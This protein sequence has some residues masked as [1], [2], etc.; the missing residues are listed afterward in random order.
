MLK[1][2]ALALL[3]AL[4]MLAPTVGLVGI[5]LFATPGTEAVGAGCLTVPGDQDTTGPL[6]DDAPVPR[7]AR[8]WIREAARTCPHLPEVWI[9]AVMYQES[10]FDPTVFADDVNGGTWGLFQI[11]RY[12]WSDVYGPW[13][14]DK[15]HNG[16][17]DIKEPLIHAKYGAKYFCDLLKL[18]RDTRKEHPGWA[19]TKDLT[20]LEALAVAHNGGPGRLETYPDIAPVTREY[21]K[22]VRRHMKQWADPNGGKTDTPDVS[23]TRV[24]M[25][26]PKG[27]YRRSS[28]YGPRDDPF[29]GGTA[30]HYGQ[31][32]AADDGTPI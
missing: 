14:T 30:F 28:A 26:L 12:E 8:A 22:D 3:A 7:K 13:E 20:E 25:P 29:G 32:Y 17:W 19:S 10:S 11:N 2:L 27:T 23:S 15:N 6:A 21:I 4:V 1:K 31:D 24:V 5:G 16:T 9:A 18:V